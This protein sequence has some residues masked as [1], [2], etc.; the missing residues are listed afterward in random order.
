MD[1]A[2]ASLAIVGG[3][4]AGNGANGCRHGHDHDD[5]DNP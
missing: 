3:F 2:V 5:N 4:L 1:G